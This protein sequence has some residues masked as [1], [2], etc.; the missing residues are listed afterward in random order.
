MSE[1]TESG[2]ILAKPGD[3]PGQEIVA[4]Q[5][6]KVD[7]RTATLLVAEGRRQATDFV[8]K[9][10]AKIVALAEGPLTKNGKKRDR[11][12][13]QV[14]ADHRHAVRALARFGSFLAKE[15]DGMQV[16]KMAPVVAGDESAEAM[17]NAE[18]GKGE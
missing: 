7:R 14:L 5:R 15:I 10:I 2:I 13:H 9:E 11:P 17:L 3:V 18:Y 12:R 6:F 1:R 4:P 8:V 16:L